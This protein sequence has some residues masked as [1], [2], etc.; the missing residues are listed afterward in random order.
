MT[1]EAGEH[2]AGWGCVCVRGSGGSARSCCSQEM[3]HGWVSFDLHRISKMRT[4]NLHICIVLLKTPCC[5][6]VSCTIRKSSTSE[7]LFLDGKVWLRRSEQRKS[8]RKSYQAEPGWEEFPEEAVARTHLSLC[9][10]NSYL[11]PM[12]SPLSGE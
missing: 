8:R 4:Q 10:L 5:S 3:L 7:P 11:G 1:Y 2:E 9:S 6:A 12:L